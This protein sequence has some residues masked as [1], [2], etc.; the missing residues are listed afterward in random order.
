LATLSELGLSPWLLRALAFAWGSVWGS[1]V[2]VVI[3]RVPRDMS[4]VRPGS[5]CPACEA[6]V[7][8]F[9]NVPL[10]SFLVLRGRARCCGARISP[11]YFVVEGL[12]GL[13]S[14]A[15]YEVVVRALPGNA[16]LV[17]GGSVFLADSGLAFA[18]VAAAFI[19]AEH[20]FLPDAI[21]LG[22]AALGLATPGLRGLG[23]TDV[24]LGAAGGFLGVWLPLIVGYKALRGRA[25]MGL[26]DAKLLMLAGA[27]FGWRGAVFALF[28]GAVQATIAAGVLLLVHGKV[29]EPEAVRKDRDELRAAAAAGD[30]EAQR[31]LELDPLASAPGE[32]LMA[33]RLP[34][35]PFLCLAIIEWML[36][37]AA[38]TER[39]L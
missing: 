30:P 34:F 27:W 19:D 16:P 17:L 33:A 38:I 3:F 29:E 6:A 39:W 28:A 9:D 7:A 13:V 35:G 20:M 11:R 26:G 31:A 21:T 4:V 1:F 2:N 14:L 24:L 8:P 32:G 22:G 12:C 36:A 37:G 25:G 23:W 15:V 10:L 18:L 5:H